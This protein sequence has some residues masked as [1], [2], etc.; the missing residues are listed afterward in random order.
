MALPTGTIQQPVGEA[1]IPPTSDKVPAFTK[2]DVIKYIKAHTMPFSDTP[3][4][5]IKGIDV[6]FITSRE[7]NTLVNRQSVGIPDDYPLCLARLSGRFTFSGP[8]GTNKKSSSGTYGQ[9]YEVFDARTGNLLMGGALG[10][11]IAG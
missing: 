5:A 9:A 1:A 11:P 8:P 3:P 10:E 4:S 6:S 2:E 7:V